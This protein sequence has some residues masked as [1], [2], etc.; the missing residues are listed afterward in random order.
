[1]IDQDNELTQM[2]LEQEISLLFEELRFLL[3]VSDRPEVV[4]V[5]QLVNQASQ[6]WQNTIS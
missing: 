5:E 4:H 3:E 2:R 6:I 1:M